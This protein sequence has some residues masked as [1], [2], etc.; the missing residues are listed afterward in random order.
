MYGERTNHTESSQ[1]GRAHW[2]LDQGLRPGDRVALHWSNSIE[3]V[4]LF[5]APFKARLVCC[6]RSSN[7]EFRRA[8]RVKWAASRSG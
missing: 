1:H 8:R 2:F 3:V 5:F 4:Q 7:T 6:R